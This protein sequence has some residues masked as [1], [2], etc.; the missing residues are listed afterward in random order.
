MKSASS[1]GATP[2]FPYLL[3]DVDLDQHLGLR[4]AVEAEP[5]E[6]RI[7][8][9]RVDQPHQRQDLPDLAALQVA[10]EVPGEVGGVRLVLGGEILLPVLPDQAD[11]GLNQRP[12][13]LDRHVLAGDEDFSP[14]G[15]LPRDLLEVGADPRPGRCRGRACVASGRSLGGASLGLDP[16]QVAHAGR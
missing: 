8:A 7:G 12:H 2:P 6:H 4:R 1:A 3:G 14:P 10:D 13:F 5:L 15:G 9:D 16:G 11:S